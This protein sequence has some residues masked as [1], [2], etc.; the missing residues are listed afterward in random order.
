MPPFFFLLRRHRAECVSIQSIQMARFLVFSVVMVFVFS[1]SNTPLHAESWLR[2]TFRACPANT[3][4]SASLLPSNTNAVTIDEENGMIRVVNNGKGKPI[5][6]IFRIYI[7][8][9]GVEY[10]A[11]Q[12]MVGSGN[13]CTFRSRTRFF[14]LTDDQ[15]TEVTAQV[16]PK[17]KLSD[18]YGKRGPKLAFESESVLSSTKEH[19]ETGE[20]MAI[21]Y[22]L[23]NFGYRI[24][25][26]M[27]PQC[28]DG[29]KENLP[30]YEKIFEAAEYSIIELVWNR[31]E[32][33][34]EVD[35]KK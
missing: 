3:S 9:N 10:F 13:E 6:T 11:H 21:H 17:L 22:G 4:A 7:G 20:G 25:S 16:L 28:G 14:T 23:P 35:I 24:F 27:L 31:E 18:F 26:R 2:E 34:F 33:K 30:E 12:R 19:Y 32:N 1:L 29:K 15:W 8:K 5:V